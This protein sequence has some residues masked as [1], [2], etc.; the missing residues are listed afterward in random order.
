MPNL[1]LKPKYDRLKFKFHHMMSSKSSW[2]R[3]LRAVVDSCS[4]WPSYESP[5][6]TWCKWLRF[7]TDRVIGKGQGTKICVAPHHENLTPEALRYG[8]HSFYT[9]N[10]PYMPLPRKRLSDGATSG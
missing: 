6:I 5:V 8:S 7:W 10:T 1:A 3:L 2:M 9:A 4:D